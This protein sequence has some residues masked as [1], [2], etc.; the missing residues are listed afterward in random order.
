MIAIAYTPP[1][2]LDISGTASELNQVQEM[3][4]E[5]I[6]SKRQE[7]R[8]EADRTFAPTPYEQSIAALIV[9]R[10]TGPTLISVLDQDVVAV[11]ADHCLEAFASWFAWPLDAK[12][13]AHAHYEYFE[14]NEWIAP[15]S[16]PLVIGIRQTE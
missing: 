1:A 14:G 8:I 4:L 16:I 12:F 6:R 2:D 11:G 15:K 3:V 5:L 13:S 10:G 9:R 7:L